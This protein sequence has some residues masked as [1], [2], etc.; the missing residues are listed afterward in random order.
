MK[1]QMHNVIGYIHS[2][3]A[4]MLLIVNR[5][6]L[7]RD[8]LWFCALALQGDSSDS[9]VDTGSTACCVFFVFLFVFMK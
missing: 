9:Y 4:N 8:Y 3:T 5:C 6:A 7:C 1:P 2:Q